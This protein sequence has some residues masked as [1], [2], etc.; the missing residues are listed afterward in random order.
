MGPIKLQFG[1][2]IEAV[3]TQTS[4]CIHNYGMGCFNS[5]TALRPW[6]H[7]C[8]GNSMTILTSFNSATAL[9]PWKRRVCSCCELER[10]GLQFG[11]GIEAVETRRLFRR[12][13]ERE[14]F[15]SAT[16][17]RPWK[18]DDSPPGYRAEHESFNSATAF[19]PW[20]PQKLLGMSAQ[21]HLLQFGHG[22]EAVETTAP[23]SGRSGCLRLQFGHGIEAVETLQDPP[24][25]A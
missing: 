19:R 2:G 5:A 23:R 18:R 14:R 16:A 21:I 3:E 24:P 25:L 22:I 6:K 7:L 4:G 8:Q 20:K 17:L 15:N 9:R 12:L 13:P 10:K 11:H 1:N